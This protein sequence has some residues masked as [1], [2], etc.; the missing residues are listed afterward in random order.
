MLDGDELPWPLTK[1]AEAAEAAAAAAAA[2]R[3][4]AN[5][6]APDGLLCW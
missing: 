2:E 1:A 6:V 5:V 3:G 4:Q